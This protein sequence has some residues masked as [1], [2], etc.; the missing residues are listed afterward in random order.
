MLITKDKALILII[1]FALINSSVFIAFVPSGG[2]RLIIA[3]L[4][5]FSAILL[6]INLWRTNF[7]ILD[8]HQYF[9]LLLFLLIIWGVVVFCR[10]FTLNLDSLISLFG[11]YLMGWTWLCPIAFV[12][13]NRV[14]TWYVLY[15]LLKVLLLFG[16]GISIFVIPII[17]TKL[18]TGLLEWF[19]LFPLFFLFFKHQ[20]LQDKGIALFSICLFLLMSYFASQRA[21]MLFVMLFIVFF[22]I[23]YL[24]ERNKKAAFIKFLFYTFLFLI[25]AYLLYNIEFVISRFMS[26]DVLVHDTRTFLV[27][28]LFQDMKIT[29]LIWGRGSLGT[30]YSPYFDYIHSRGLEGGDWYHRQVNEI[31]YLQMLLK[32]GWVMVFLQVLIL[33]PA[34]FLGI[35]KSANVIARSCGY[36]ILA[37][38]LLWFVSYY[39]V[40]S[41][42][43]IF[44]WIA[45]GATISP[46]LRAK[47]NNELSF[48]Y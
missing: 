23:E 12:Y 30:Y 14:N 47:K 3:A 32:G 42:E 9:K 20:N 13:G 17:D 22:I 11:H 41:A 40:Y 26:N 31:G 19:V 35:F 46:T 25:I 10:S 36:Y 29:E 18:A 48:K 4:M 34:A 8:C 37:Y 27:I 44:L 1:V 24:R 21:N 16:M 15:R 38:L 2:V 39:P 43:Y 33:L 7:S 5:N 45:L 28:E 6:V